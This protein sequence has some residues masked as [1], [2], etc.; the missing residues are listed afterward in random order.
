MNKVIMDEPP[1]LMNGN[2]IPTTG[3][4]P[5]TMLIFTN[6]LNRNVSS[7]PP[8]TNLQN[9]SRAFKAKYNVLRLRIRI[10]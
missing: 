6:K 8:T 10:T 9:R 2:G 5:I 1:L 3:I 7:S 4:K